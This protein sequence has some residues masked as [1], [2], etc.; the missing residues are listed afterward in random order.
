M[1]S[2]GDNRAGLGLVALICVVTIGTLVTSHAARASAREVR[3]ADKYEHAAAAIAAEESLERKYRLEPSPAAKAAH[4]AAEVSLQ[5][6][7]R[8]VAALGN[9]TNEN[10]ARVVLSEHKTYI[11]T[12]ARLFLSVDR[13][14]PAAVTNAIDG[15]AVD[16]VFHVM[17]D[18]V[19]GAAAKHEATALNATA[20]VRMVSRFALIVD[21]VTL[22][23]GI[24]LVGGGAVVV[25][26][27]QQDLHSESEQN[28]YQSL[29]DPLTDLPNRTLFQ[30]RTGVALRTAALGRHRGRASPGPQP[31]QGSQ[32]HPRP[33]LR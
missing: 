10:L 14:D 5:Q 25:T 24:G 21:L 23:A 15:R 13:H 33:S 17:E 1:E 28:R 11:A 4:T 2:V 26:R 32:R 31:V 27:Y 7:M 20:S 12:S 18:Q 29:H 6:A 3:T 8:Q 22:V 16:P 19:Y 30:D 9:S